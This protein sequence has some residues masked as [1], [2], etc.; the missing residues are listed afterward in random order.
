MG[1]RSIR[2]APGLCRRLAIMLSLVCRD[3][4]ASSCHLCRQAFAYACNSDRVHAL[5]V[6]A[7]APRYEGVQ[8]GTLP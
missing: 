3:A 4:S 1:T 2:F 6:P 5:Y 8:T 7:H